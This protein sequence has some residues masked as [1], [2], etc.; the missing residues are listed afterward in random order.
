[1]VLDTVLLVAANMGQR[2]FF[3]NS[4]LPM[5]LYLSYGLALVLGVIE[6]DVVRLYT[7]AGRQ[8]SMALWQSSSFGIYG[9]AQCSGRQLRGP[10]G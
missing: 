8:T 1:M 6:L 10:T 9:I 2:R 5:V 3:N 4:V 7:L